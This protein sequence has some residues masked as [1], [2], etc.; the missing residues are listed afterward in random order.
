MELSEEAPLCVV[1][2]EIDIELRTLPDRETAQKRS[3]ELKA[4][5]QAIAKT[6]APER[7][8][9]NAELRFLGAEDILSYVILKQEGKLKVLE[10]DLPVEVQVIGIGDTRIVGLQGEIFVEF[11]LTIQYRSPFPKTF[12]IELANGVLLGYVATA[13]AYAAGGYETGASMQTGRSG[14]QLVDAAVE[15]LYQ[16]T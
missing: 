13:R 11:G 15:L 12:V 6:D 3:D 1:S 10:D 8:I 5:W 2:K 9:W 7:D 4:E 16:T 14:E